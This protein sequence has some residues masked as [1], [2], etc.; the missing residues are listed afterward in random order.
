MAR[1]RKNAAAPIWDEKNGYWYLKKQ[2]HG[3]RKTFR[4]YIRGQRGSDDCEAQAKKWMT[5]KRH[6]AAYGKDDSEIPYNIRVKELGEKWVAELQIAGTS[7]D[8]YN[9]YSGYLRNYVYPR[10][11]SRRIH[12]IIEQDLQDIILHA[13]THPFDSN[14]SR[15]SHKSLTKIRACLVSFFK[16][17]RKCGVSTLRPEDLYIPKNAPKGKKL[18]LLKS[19]L[20]ILFSED[21]TLYRGKIIKDWYIHAYRIE[22]I[23]GLRPGELAHIQDKRDIKGNRCFLRGAINVHGEFTQGKNENAIRNYILPELAAQEI[24]AQRQMLKEAGV[25]SPYLFP[26]RD[27]EH[28][29]YQTYRSSWYRYRNYHA[30]SPRTLYEMRH[31]YFAINK[32]NP[33]EL[34]KIMAGHS[35]KF[36][37]FDFYGGELEDDSQELAYIIDNTVQEILSEKTPDSPS[38]VS[39]KGSK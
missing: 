22:I 21:T 33:V 24:A 38:I 15:L 14:R 26:G 29:V 5:S 34:L 2:Y 27:G 25:V 16:Y 36:N 4:S 12:G 20:K 18:P 19:D 6:E 28:L 9:Q 3:E 31:T 13:F 1:D 30:L 32:K 23:L 10:Y 37:S 17:A 8:Y 7:R 39:I 11:G 35:E